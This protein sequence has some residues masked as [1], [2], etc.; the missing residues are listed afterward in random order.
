ML[1]ETHF[2]QVLMFTGED[3]I[4]ADPKCG[5]HSKKSLS[6]K[7][8]FIKT[9]SSRDWRNCSL[10][11]GGGRRWW[12]LIIGQICQTFHP[13]E[14][15]WF[16]KVIHTLTWMNYFLSE[17]ITEKVKIVARGWFGGLKHL[18]ESRAG[19]LSRVGAS[20][21]SESLWRTGYPWK[22]SEHSAPSPSS[23]YDYLLSLDFSFV[24]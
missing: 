20:R 6:S 16:N 10:F 8:C 4:E 13:L 5:I 21:K 3:N 9:T 24:K 11:S 7:Y 19:V 22:K 18:R 23:N 2:L 15:Q 17:M 14:F 12:M 1:R